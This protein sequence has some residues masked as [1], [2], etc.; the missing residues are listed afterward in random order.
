MIWAEK[1]QTHTRT[2]TDTETETETE[3]TQAA[4]NRYDNF[5]DHLAIKLQNAKENL[6]KKI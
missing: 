6:K 2:I 1:V 3:S 5:R 4:R